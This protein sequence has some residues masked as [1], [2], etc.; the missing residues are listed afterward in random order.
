MR[1]SRLALRSGAA[2]GGPAGAALLR[3]SSELAPVA[4]VAAAAGARAPA[5]HGPEAAPPVHARPEAMLDSEVVAVELDWGGERAHYER[6]QA[7]FAADP[8]ALQRAAPSILLGEA[9]IPE[10]VALLRALEDGGAPAVT[11]LLGLVLTS[12]TENERG[13]QFL[14]FA[15]R[16]LSRRAPEDPAARVALR[17]VVWGPRASPDGALRRRAAG[18]LGATATEDELAAGFPELLAEGDALVVQAFNS[19]LA[20]RNRELARS[21]GQ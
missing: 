2:T 10:R 13:G 5:S 17:E 12:G 18:H 20:E 4:D 1:R 15:L 21:F 16:R 3:A 14:D 11:S 7:L 9:S 8:V 19:A 6:F